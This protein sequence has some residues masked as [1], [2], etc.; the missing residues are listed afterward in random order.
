MATRKLLAFDTE[1]SKPILDMR[2]WRRER[3][4]GISCGTTFTSANN[5][6]S[7][8]GGEQPDGRLREQ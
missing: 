7:W 5:M 4:L 6:R 2:R 8:H 1:I 3:P